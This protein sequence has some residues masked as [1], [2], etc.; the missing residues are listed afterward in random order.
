MNQKSKIKFDNQT[1]NS[2]SGVQQYYVR[3]PNYYQQQ[4]QQTNPYYPQ[5]Q[6]NPYYPQ[7]PNYTYIPTVTNEKKLNISLIVKDKSY[8]SRED[9]CR[10]AISS[11]FN[12]KISGSFSIVLSP[13][14][15][16]TSKEA[17][18]LFV[19]DYY[20]MVKIFPEI[21]KKLKESKANFMCGFVIP[22]FIESGK[23]DLG[24]YYKTNNG[25]FLY[26]LKKNAITYQ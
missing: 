17:T 18:Q 19:I 21:T 9:V 12:L 15:N 25:D 26:E 11:N 4:Q 16:E 20:D 22:F 23:L 24:I 14:L 1:K 13:N 5:Q 6:T 10:I 8:Y 2:Y 7:Q 3:Q